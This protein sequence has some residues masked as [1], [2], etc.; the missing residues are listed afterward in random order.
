MYSPASAQGAEHTSIRRRDWKMECTRPRHYQ[1]GSGF[2]GDSCPRKNTLGSFRR[3][4][5][6]KKSDL[7]AQR[8]NSPVG[9][10]EDPCQLCVCRSVP[11]S[12]MKSRLVSVSQTKLNALA[13]WLSLYPMERN[14]TRSLREGSLG[15]FGRTQQPAHAHVADFG[16]R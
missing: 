2:L 16:R 14:A 6:A 7:V 8:G 3:Y 13:R 9:L 12:T 10:G 11:A 1:G 5:P 15:G 4:N